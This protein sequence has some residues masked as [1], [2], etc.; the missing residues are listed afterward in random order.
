MDDRRRPA[1]EM[2]TADVNCRE[3][4]SSS[5]VRVVGADAFQACTRIRTA[6]LPRAVTIE[7]Y[8]SRQAHWQTSSPDG[9]H[10]RQTSQNCSQ[11]SQASLSSVQNLSE[12]AF[13]HCSSLRTVEL[14]MATNLPRL[15]FA[16]CRN[17]QRVEAPLAFSVGDSAFERRVTAQ[18]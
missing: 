16:G 2:M 17:L 13:Q 5:E 1:I 11:L 12:T 14:P 6:L 3:A 10:H 8:I 4:F 15:A 9:T 18:L 7:D